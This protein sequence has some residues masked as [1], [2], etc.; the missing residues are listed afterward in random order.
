LLTSFIGRQD[1][2]AF[3][4]LVQRHGPMV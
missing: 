1:K 2:D 4:A 3:E